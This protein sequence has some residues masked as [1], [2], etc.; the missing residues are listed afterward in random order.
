MCTRAVGVGQGLERQSLVAQKQRWRGGQPREK[1][2]HV[3]YDIGRLAGCYVAKIGVAGST[4]GSACTTQGHP[5]GNNT[6]GT[7]P[8]QAIAIAPHRTPRE[9][10]ADEGRLTSAVLPHCALVD[11]VVSGLTLRSDA[12]TAGQAVTGV[13]RCHPRPGRPPHQLCSMDAG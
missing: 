3:S 12:A 4:G 5:N 6:R 2:E 8:V 1:R 9:D 10:V 7:L 13:G 11:G